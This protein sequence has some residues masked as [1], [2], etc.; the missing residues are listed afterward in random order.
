M[1]DLNNIQLRM[2]KMTKTMA[3]NNWGKLKLFNILLILTPEDK[4]ANKVFIE[5][6]TNMQVL[7]IMLNGNFC[8]NIL[9]KILKLLLCKYFGTFRSN[10]ETFCMFP[11]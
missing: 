8:Y 2:T 5:T 4:E 11:Y 6:I 3:K 1:I 9:M 10:M 7:Q